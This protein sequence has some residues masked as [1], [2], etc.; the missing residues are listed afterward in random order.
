M[1]WIMA[2]LAVAGAIAIGWISAANETLS[3]A[4]DGAAAVSVLALGAVAGAGIIRTIRHGTLF[5]TEIHSVLDN[6]VLLISG[7]YLVVYSISRLGAA[8][9]FSPERSR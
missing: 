3:R 4:A 2:A 7:S 8:V 5:M 1:E 9:F 6:P